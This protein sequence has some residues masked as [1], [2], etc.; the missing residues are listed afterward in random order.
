MKALGLVVS[1]KKIYLCFSHDAPRAE[2]VWNPGAWLAGFIKINDDFS[3][4]IVSVFNGML[5]C[6]SYKMCNFENL[7]TSTK[8]PQSSLKCHTTKINNIQ[9]FHASAGNSAKPAP[10]GKRFALLPV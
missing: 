1:E 10:R 4:I 2:P 8:T 3:I 6:V 7:L 5:F 9:L